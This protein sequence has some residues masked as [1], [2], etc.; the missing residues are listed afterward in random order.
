MSAYK[1]NTLMKICLLLGSSLLVMGNAAIGP[2]LAKINTVFNDPFGVSLLMAFPAIG[3]VLSSP[4]V[5]KLMKKMGDKNTLLIGLFIYGAAGSSGLWLDSIPALLFFRLLF[6]LSIAICMTVINEIIGRTFQGQSRTKF[7]SLQSVA[8]NLGGIV[9]VSL[10]GMLAEY[11]WR[12]PFGLYLLAFVIFMM[13]IQVVTIPALVDNEIPK[14]LTLSDIKGVLPAYILGFMGMLFYYI[15]LMNLPFILDKSLALSTS[16]IG[17]VMALMS[18]IS[19]TIAYLFRHLL[20][21]F[22]E[23]WLLVLCFCCYAIAFVAL[24]QT[25]FEWRAYVAIVFGGISFG[26]LLPTLSHLVILLSNTVLRVRLMSG[27]VMFYFLGQALSGIFLQLNYFLPLGLL[28]LI[29]AIIAAITACLCLFFLD[30]KE[31]RINIK[32]HCVDLEREL[33]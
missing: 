9:F 5:D 16:M 22:G 3:V 4:F 17:M 25:Q 33:S 6:G 11:S 29:L 10:S 24:S 7:I 28:F 12:F 26:L 14:R 23:R 18:F 30:I 13:S 32:E 19:A 1:A 8:V 21:R 20:S 15:V 27:F 2:A 31:H